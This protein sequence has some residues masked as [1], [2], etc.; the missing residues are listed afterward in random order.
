MDIRIDKNDLLAKISLGVNISSSKATTL[1]ILS[2]LLLETKK[3]KLQIVATDMEVGVLTSCGAEIKE[4][5][6]VTAPAR[7]FYDI[8]KELPD[9]EMEIQVSKNHTVQIKSGKS[10]FKVMGMDKEDYPQLP[11]PSLEN[12][13]E[14]EQ[15]ILKEALQLT[16]FAVSRD[17]T[18]YVLNGILVSFKADIFRCVATDGRR[19]AYY[20]KKIPSKIKKDVEI[21]IPSKAVHELS[22]LLSW[23]GT[24]QISIF[25]NKVVFC[26]ANT[27][28]SATIIEGKFPNYEQVIP[29][30][31][32]TTAEIN[33]NELLQCLRR[34][35]LLTSTEA[36]AVKVDFLK[37]R[38]MIT[39]RTPNLGEAKE[40]AVS[41]H[42][43][44]EMTIGFNPDYL[45]DVL[46]NL[47]TDNI[48][49]TLS[50]ADKPGVVEGKEGYLYVIMPMQIH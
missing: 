29:K 35:A 4:E 42:E 43:G 37:G 49:F 47:E 27:F 30:G 26:V 31:K 22:K 41:R 45:M 39:A 33:R 8:I 7:K 48:L 2:N 40:E 1:P 34:A 20:E 32:G 16:S 21:I 3:N 28:L 15:S 12:A 13:I 38:V 23:D 36:P 24:V 6:S 44:K 11:E 46:K 17:E 9:G 10:V 14:I 50:D 5:G 19:L 18:R 25:Q